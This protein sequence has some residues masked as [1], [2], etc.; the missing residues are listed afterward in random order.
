MNTLTIQ[1][2]KLET[3]SKNTSNDETNCEQLEKLANQYNRDGNKNFMASKYELAVACYEKAINLD[4]PNKELR[5][6]ILH[7]MAT[8]YYFAKNYR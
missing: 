8:T 3:F 4:F 6:L 7:N 1:E 2:R 5:I